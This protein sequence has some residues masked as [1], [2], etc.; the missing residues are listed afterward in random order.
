MSFQ[1]PSPANNVR[2]HRG[3]EMNP[4]CGKRGA[5][6]LVQGTSSPT[7]VKNSDTRV[8][9]SARAS[10]NYTRN[11]GPAQA[12]RK[13]ALEH[14]GWAYKAGKGVTGF[15]KRFFILSECMLSYYENEAGG[16]VKGEVRA[17]ARVMDDW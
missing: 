11:V 12:T 10:M 3:A 4:S 16:K 1:S 14:T 9:D 8:K 6:A 17:R 7:R 13:K 2:G 15:K 5:G